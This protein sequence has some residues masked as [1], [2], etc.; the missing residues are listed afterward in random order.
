MPVQCVKRPF[1]DEATARREIGRFN[2]N[3]RFNQIERAAYFCRQCDAWHVRYPRR[4]A[5]ATDITA[6]FL[7]VS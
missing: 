2:K 5:Q 6:G 7:P 4:S 1:A 3:G